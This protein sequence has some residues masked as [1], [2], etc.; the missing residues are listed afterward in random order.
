MYIFPL[1]LEDSHL[2]TGTWT[3]DSDLDM[4]DSV[5]NSDNLGSVLDSDSDWVDSTPAL[6][7]KDKIDLKAI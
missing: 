6:K 1:E 5:L 2:D 4:V 3:R 7:S